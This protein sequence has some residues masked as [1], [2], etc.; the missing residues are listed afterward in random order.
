MIRGIEGSSIFV[1]D[2]DRQAVRTYWNFIVEGEE[3]G[4]RPER[5]GGGKSGNPEG[6]SQVIS[7]RSAIPFCDGFDL[8]VKAAS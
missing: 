6:W 7:L 4:R 1:D 8:S 5:G 2:Q 3:Q